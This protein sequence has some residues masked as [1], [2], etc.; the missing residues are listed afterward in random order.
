MEEEVV[1]QV[2]EPVYYAGIDVAHWITKIEDSVI[3]LDD[4]SLFYVYDED[5]YIS[6]LWAE[7]N[8]VVVSPTEVMGHYY[9]TK[10]G[11]IYK[12]AETLRAIC[13]KG[14]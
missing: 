7:K 8:D 11:G 5:R 1:E 3:Q 14:Q 6:K 13:V 2:L 10:D 12:E 4:N 9:I